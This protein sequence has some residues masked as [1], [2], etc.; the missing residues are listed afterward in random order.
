MAIWDMADRS[1]PT[2]RPDLAT[3][4]R[5]EAPGVRPPPDL[6]VSPPPPPPLRCI[7]G[8]V[9]VRDKPLLP[10]WRP[11]LLGVPLP[12]PMPL[13]APLPTPS[14]PRRVLGLGR[15]T[16]VPPPWGESRCPAAAASVATCSRLTSGSETKLL[17][18]SLRRLLAVGRGVVLWLLAVNADAALERSS[19]GL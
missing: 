1:L 19:S 3:R 8:A 6:G 15:W 16:G 14:P 4:L 11:P 18:R 9:A 17:R 2:R 13:P 10:C 5:L 12:V 7:A